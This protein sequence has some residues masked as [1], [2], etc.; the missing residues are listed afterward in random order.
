MW[1]STPHKQLNFILGTQPSSLSQPNHPGTIP[2]RPE[3]VFRI[4]EKNKNEARICSTN[5]DDILAI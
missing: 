5:L 3:V 2:H 4:Y 1:L